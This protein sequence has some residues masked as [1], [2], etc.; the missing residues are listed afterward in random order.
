M[1]FYGLEM[2]NYQ[3]IESKLRQFGQ[4]FYTNELI[5]GIILFL[6]LG[7]L[8]F[9]FTLFIEYFLWLKPNARTF[10]F[11]LFIGVELFLFVRFICFPI[12]KLIGLKKG[13]SLEESSKIIG[14]HFPEVQDKLLNI[15]Q[16]KENAKSSELLLAS[17]EQ[18]STELQPIPFSKAIDFKKNSKYLKYALVPLLIWVLVFFT[19]SNG[20]LTKS[21]QRVVDY[22]TSYNPPAPFSFFIDNASLTVIQGKPYTVKVKVKGNVIP[23][24]AKIAYD[25]QE[26][27]LQNNLDGSFSYTFSDVQQP[28]NFYIKANEITSNDYVLDVIKTPTIQ[29]VSMFLNFP[30]H[31]KRKSKKINNTG[32]ITVPEGT[33]ITWQVSASQTDTVS[34]IQQTR[35][36]FTQKEENVFRYGKR[37]L[38]PINYSIS[39]SNKALKDYEKLQFSV[40]VVKDEFPV[41]SMTSNIDSI[42]RGT[43]QFAGQVSDDYGLKKLELVYYNE[44]NP[45]PQQT[46]ELPLSKE[47]IQTFY[48]QFPD[49][50]NLVEG[51]DYELFFR[52]FDNDAVNGN[53]KAVSRK[54]NYRKKTKEEVDEELMEEQKNTLNSLENSIQQQK[55]QQEKLEKIQQDIQNKKNISWNDKKKVQDF[56]KL[57]KQYKEMMQ[58]QTDKLQENFDEKKEE[59]PSLQEKKEQLQERINELKKSAYQEK[60]L[61]E[62]QKMSEKLNKED[63][64]KKSKELAQQNKQQQRSLERMLE[65]TKR[66][67]VEQKTMQIA[68]K[69]EELSKKQEE[70]SK[71]E[72]NNLEKQKEIKK[73]FSKLEKELKELNKENEELKKPMELPETDSEQDDINKELENS[74]EKLEEQNKKEA[75]ESQKKSSKKMKKMSQKMQQQMQQNSSDSI[76]EDMGDLRKI[77]ENLVTFSFKQEGL[78]NRFSESSTNHPD[79]GKN[80]KKQNE[81]KTYFNHIDD[82]LYVLSVRVPKIS[83][84]IQ[85]D[86]SLAHYNLNQSLDNFSENRFSAGVS[87]QRYVMTASNSLADYLSNIL[88]NMK[89]SMSMGKGKGKK[90]QSFSLPTI[91]EKQKGLSE[92]MKKGMEKGQKPGEK[93]S[94]SGKDGKEGKEGKKGEKGGQK[95]NGKDGG[96][97]GKGKQGKNGKGGEKEGEGEG[98]SDDLDGELYKIYKEQSQLR[99][100][101]EDAINKGKFGSG[102]TKQAAKVA[103]EMEQL[104]NQIL[105]KGINARTFQRMQQLNYQLLKLK[106]AELKQG[107]DSK[108]K[109][110]TNLKEYQRKKRKELEF[111]KLF[112]NQTEILNRQ[113]LPLRPNYKKKVQEYFSL[114]KSKN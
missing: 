26:Y 61:K 50:L 105:E 52:V 108:R 80:L 78:I 39:S 82:S 2:K 28:I 71:S 67:Y 60:L 96:K 23:S 87:N 63:L 74:E 43:A 89:E 14:N 27:Y 84:R 75:K 104:E 92:K 57:Q 13:I 10:L 93:A 40:D 41:I 91:I 35:K 111:K 95:E 36:S 85:E 114:P 62:L 29:Q 106:S 76:E 42:S 77:L 100:Q 46:L 25:H 7:F 20:A 86:L 22:K 21:L 18:K 65:M 3:H 51:I 30:N 55:K 72:E 32:N 19:G 9:F 34:F 107:K 38:K 1:Y 8:Y 70:L 59:T 11:W 110:A 99:Q 31:I 94:E 98:E 88:N 83:A 109:A 44:E 12:F 69:L 97:G 73:E 54:F 45:Q 64:L 79:F 112:Y 16:L 53:K 5:K 17:I 56:I 37:I 102:G 68:S 24:E 4:K 49:Q 15:L 103:K 6:T 47:N 48:Y 33:F 66:F 101:L 90:G 81:I 58:R 113:S